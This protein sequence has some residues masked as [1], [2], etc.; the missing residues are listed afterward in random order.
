LHLR[1]V[2]ERDAE[3]AHG[4]TARP[5]N[6][7]TTVRRNRARRLLLAH[8][9]HTGENEAESRTWQWHLDGVSAV[10]RAAPAPRV[11][12]LDD[13][14]D[15]ATVQDVVRHADNTAFSWPE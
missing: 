1:R 14:P 5:H 4:I 15:A 13:G 8:G 11:A 7:L 3:D 12:E 9:R 10:N 2:G 6:P